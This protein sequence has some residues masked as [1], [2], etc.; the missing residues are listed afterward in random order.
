MFGVL[1][2]FVETLL[3]SLRLW[4]VWAL[5]RGIWFSLSCLACDQGPSE[6]TWI[7]VTPD[8]GRDEFARGGIPH[9]SPFPDEVSN[10]FLLLLMQL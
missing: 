5:L 8:G 10:P 6:F 7:R 1:L 4:W 2:L 9:T 3:C